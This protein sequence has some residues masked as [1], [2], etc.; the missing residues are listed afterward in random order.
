MAAIAWSW[1]LE[2]RAGEPVE[3]AHDWRARAYT[4]GGGTWLRLDRTG[5]AV[6]AGGLG[7]LAIDQA[8]R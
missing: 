3:A 5:H 7:S 1:W 2:A 6:D 4:V 8:L